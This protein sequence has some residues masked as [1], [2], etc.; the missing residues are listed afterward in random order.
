MSTKLA[1]GLEMSEIQDCVSCAPVICF[2]STWLPTFDLSPKHGNCHLH[3]SFNRALD[4]SWIC[5]NFVWKKLCYRRAT[6]LWNS[7]SATSWC[8]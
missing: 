8:M 6:V 1:A 7:L 5:S 2:N 3:S 4:V